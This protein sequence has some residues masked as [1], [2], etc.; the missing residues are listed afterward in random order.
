MSGFYIFFLSFIAIALF[1][2]AVFG[3]VGGI[4]ELAYRKARPR[5]LRKIFGP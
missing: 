4:I 1:A 5:W 2:L 3:V